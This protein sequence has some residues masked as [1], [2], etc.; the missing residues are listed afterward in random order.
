MIDLIPINQ[1]YDTSLKMNQQ[2]NPRLKPGYRMKKK[3][4]SR[5]QTILMRNSQRLEMQRLHQILLKMM[6]LQKP[7]LSDAQR[8]KK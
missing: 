3:Q 7:D 8:G 5:R 6:T 4:P 1:I 2:Q